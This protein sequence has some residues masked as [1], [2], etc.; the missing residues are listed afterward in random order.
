MFLFFQ[1]K[2]DA[3]RHAEFHDFVVLDMRRMLEYFNP[4]Y[5]SQGLLRTGKAFDRSVDP[6]LF[7][8]SNYLCYACYGNFRL[9]RGW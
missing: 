3:H 5:V 6:S 1:N 9:L 7:G 8:R 2:N 4:G